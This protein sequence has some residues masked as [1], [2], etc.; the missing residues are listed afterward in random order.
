MTNKALVF[1]IKRFAV[2]DGPGTRTTVFLK[3]C[4]L[5]CVWCHNP[6]SISTG[7][8]KYD[9]FNKLG[10]NQIKTQIEVGKLYTVKEL[11]DQIEKDII[12]FDQSGGGVTFSGGEPL[13]QCNFLLEMLKLCKS[14]EI[15]TVVDTSAY[16]KLDDLKKIANYV[17]LFL[18]DIK[19]ISDELHQK[20]TGRSNKI[21]I[22][23]LKY[24]DSINKKLIIRLPVIPSV[25]DFSDNY[26]EIILLLKE[27][28][29][30][31]EINLLPYHNF[32]Q[33]KYPKFNIDNKYKRN[34]NLRKE[35]CRWIKDLF[36]TNGFNA[37]IV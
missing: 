8:T 29:H 24:L 6:E 13:M 22:E 7:I 19:I 23:N 5:N 16:C 35:D 14:N 9:M 32:G 26:N 34:E 25:N 12:F 18:F 1:D 31:Y 11:F 10:D 36:E 20:Y 4:P 33:A 3:S 17:D 21:I 27:L 30:S 2:H 37:K 15:H 28:N